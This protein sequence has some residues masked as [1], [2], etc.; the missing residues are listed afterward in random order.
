VSLRHRHLREDGFP[1]RQGE[2]ALNQPFRH[3]GILGQIYTGELIKE[4][5]VGGR[6]GVVPT[7]SGKAW[8]TG[9]TTWVLDAEIRFPTAS[10]LAT[11]G[12]RRTKRGKVSATSQRARTSPHPTRRFCAQSHECG[13]KEP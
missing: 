12:L 9:Y 5:T 7:L 6:V 3:E 4:V 1:V 10:R 8:I 11:S 2:L 13:S